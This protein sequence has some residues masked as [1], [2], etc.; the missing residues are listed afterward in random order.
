MQRCI[1]YLLLE[2]CS[3]CFGWYLHLSSGAHTQLFL[4]YL[5]LVKPLLLPAAVVEE[6]ELV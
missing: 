4:Q 1:V 5:L 2:N 3:T 6:L